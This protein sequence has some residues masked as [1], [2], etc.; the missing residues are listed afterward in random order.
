MAQAF[1]RKKVRMHSARK[2]PAVAACSVLG[3]HYPIAH[4][5]SE[6]GIILEKLSEL[7]QIIRATA[8]FFSRAAKRLATGWLV[9]SL[10]Q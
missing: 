8:I 9:Q 5:M 2:T 1:C 7:K 3:G 10:C 6:K 4:K